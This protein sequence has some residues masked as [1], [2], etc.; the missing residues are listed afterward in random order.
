[1]TPFSIHGF[2]T[3]I[4]QEVARG[5][6]GVLKSGTKLRLIY[7][8]L[9]SLAI[10]ILAEYYRFFQNNSQLTTLLIITAFCFPFFASFDGWS[11]FLIGK[12]K[13]KMFSHFQ[14][15]YTL[16]VTSVTLLAVYLG[17]KL[18]W[19][20][21]INLLT[22]GT[23]NLLLFLYVLRKYE[24]NK[25]IEKDAMVYAKKITLIDAIPLI[26]AKLDRLIAGFFLGAQP[27]AI[28][29]V[30]K[31]IPE[32]GKQIYYILSQ[33]FVPK[34]ASKRSFEVYQYT[35]KGLILF[36]LVISFSTVFLFFLIPPIY[37]FLFSGTYIKS[38]YLAQLLLFPLLIGLPGAIFDIF[39]RVSTQARQQF[40]LRT[41]PMIIYLG[42]MILF[43]PVF[44]L[45]GIILSIYI[46]TVTFS[47]L[48]SVFY[49]KNRSVYKVAR[50]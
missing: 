37:K 25:L 43:V 33:L 15:I 8:I 21:L 5:H 12:Q 30:A 49:F 31:L 38:I 34:L 11:H 47:I 9:G 2:N 18:S 4:I 50:I 17:F 19:I 29:S 7:S 6:E 26:E 46:R 44:H 35:E 22:I 10:I 3:V 1:M 14:I 13:Y 16:V 20:I 36:I 24:P 40:Y 39:F 32:Q 28:F 23:V 45:K 48:A 27:L 42:S 41:I